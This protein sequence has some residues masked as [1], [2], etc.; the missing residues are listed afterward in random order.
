MTVQVDQYV[1]YGDGCGETLSLLLC[2]AVVMFNIQPIGPVTVKCLLKVNYE[3]P[4]LTS[5]LLTL[6]LFH[7]NSEKRLLK[8][9]KMLKQ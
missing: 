6:S 7:T 8:M 4:V 9:G 1:V 2:Y 5:T 3:S